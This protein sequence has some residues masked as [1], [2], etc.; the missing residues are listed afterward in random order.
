MGV[1]FK[2]IIS[3]FKTLVMV[4][5]SDAICLAVESVDAGEGGPLRETSDAGMVLECLWM[6]KPET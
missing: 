4:V 2:N 3:L 5:N 1:R 6:P